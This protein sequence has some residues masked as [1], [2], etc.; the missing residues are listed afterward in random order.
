MSMQEELDF[1][2]AAS[3]LP[4]GWRSVKLVDL[5]ADEPNAMTDGPF[6]SKLK[7]SHYV[8]DGVRVIRLGNLGVGKFKDADRSF[9]SPE[10]AATLERHHVEAGDLLIAALAE[11]VGRACRVPRHILPA[12]VKADC[13]RFKPGPEILP[14]FLMH[15]L[16]SP[17]GR[18]NAEAHCHGV[19][20]LRINMKNM[21]QL[22]VRVAPLPEQRR[23]VAEIDKHF[24]RLDAAVATLERVRAN[25]QRARASVLKA[26]VEGRL[27]PTEASVARAEG[28]AYETGAD[29]VARVERAP[30]PNRYKTR[31]RDVIPGHGALSV[32]DTGERLPE[33]WA[34]APLVEVAKMESGHTPSRR[35]PEWWDGDVPWIGIA[36]AREHHGTVIRDTAQHTNDDG[37]ANSAARLLPTGTVCVSRTA[38]V[39][40]VTVMGRPMATSQDFANW[41]CTD[42]ID[43]HW[44]RVVFQADRQALG[45]FG[46]GSVHTTIYF[47]NLLS[48]HVAVPPMA[49]QR[50]IVTEV[51]KHLSRLQALEA[52]VEQSA[53]RCERLRQAILKRAFE[54][55]LVEP[56][57]EADAPLLAA[58]PSP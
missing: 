9:V 38:S 27:V 57:G 3:G 11:P 31:S 34:R 28:R 12:L 53:T 20:R 42:A 22:D 15:W 40:Y 49:E 32:G 14:D 56:E 58:E 17:M 48:L 7:S 35:H 47:P 8:D 46:K 54:G 1:T 18:S 24:T 51:E 26:A 23:I 37:L 45:R 21:R 44:L 30:R 13:I 41:V 29:L 33:G 6:G 50:R 43:P 55:R 16:N 36:D 39:G 5:V 52:V 25:L 10:H 19:G 4:R 2:P